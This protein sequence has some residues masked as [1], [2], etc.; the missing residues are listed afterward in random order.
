MLPI[1][2][3]IAVRRTAKGDAQ[4]GLD[5]E[6]G[7]SI[8]FAWMESS[9]SSP[10]RPVGL[11]QPSRLRWPMPGPRWHAMAIVA[12]QTG[13]ASR[14]EPS[15]ANPEVLP[16]ILA[17]LTARIYYTNPSLPRWAHRTS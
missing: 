17:R 1:A 6:W 9:R 14:Y 12:L 10:D 2:V 13:Q 5:R 8:D 16:P 4:F 7:F 11:A 3:R 15:A